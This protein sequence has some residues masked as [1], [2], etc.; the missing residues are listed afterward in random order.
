LAGEQARHLHILLCVTL[1]PI[2]FGGWN[3][4]LAGIAIGLVDGGP[5]VAHAATS[6]VLAR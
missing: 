5:D 2:F 4:P 1:L 6:A 3:V